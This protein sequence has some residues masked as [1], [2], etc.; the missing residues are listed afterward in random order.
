MDHVESATSRPSHTACP[1]PAAHTART[2]LTSGSGRGLRRSVLVSLAALTATAV[3]ATVAP[4]ASARPASA[5]PLSAPAA[6][7]ALSRPAAQPADNDPELTAR[8]LDGINRAR[9]TVRPGGEAVVYRSHGADLVY[10][11]P[12][13]GQGQ[14]QL[15][16]RTHQ[17]KRGMAFCHAAAMAAVYAIGS[18][19]LAAAALAGGITI[20][21]IA[22]SAQAAGALSTALAVGSG[23]SALVSQYV[24]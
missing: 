22:I 14:G 6:G 1:A 12:A 23:V 20:V 24:C 8:I 18:A 9:Q 5:P 4:S 3:L 10:T 17:D 7:A 15:V 21:G 11:K 16:V 19:A 13:R 2:T